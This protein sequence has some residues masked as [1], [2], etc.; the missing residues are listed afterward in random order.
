MTHFTTGGV[1]PSAPGLGA[2]RRT[3][4]PFNEDVPHTVRVTPGAADLVLAPTVDR[5]TGEFGG[6]IAG[7]V[8]AGEVSRCAAQ[9]R[10]QGSP[11]QALPELIERLARAELADRL[12]ASQPLPTG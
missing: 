7:S 9:L 10:G 5:L 4:P 1:E 6:R 12:A 8:V 2:L 3:P 11:T